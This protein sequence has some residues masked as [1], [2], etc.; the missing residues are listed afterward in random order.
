MRENKILRGIAA[1]PGISVKRV[2]IIETEEPSISEQGVTDV[3]KEIMKLSKALKQTKEQLSM[4][5]KKVFEMSDIH[6][7]KI[8]D[9][10]LLLLEDEDMIGKTVKIIR[11]TRKN[12][13]YAVKKV[14]GEMSPS[15]RKNPF[16]KDRLRDI[17]NV[18][19]KIVRNMGDGGGRTVY[20][21]M[22]KGDSVAAYDIPAFDMVFLGDVGG[23]ITELGGKTSHTAILARAFGVPAVVG[24]ESALRYL[25]SGDLVIIDGVRGV[26]V[27]NPGEETLRS[28]EERIRRYNDYRKGLT[29]L[30]TLSPTTIDGHTIEVSVNIELPMEIQPA[31]HYGADGIGLFRTEFLFINGPPTEPEQFEVYKHCAELV[32]PNSVI[33]RTVDIGGDKLLQ[34][35]RFHDTNPFLGWR[36]VRVYLKNKN[37]LRTQLRAVL[38][39]S[40]FGNVR[41]MFPFICAIEEIKLLKKELE[42]IKR[43]LDRDNIKYDRK[44]EL[45]IMV[46]IP[47][48]VILARDFAKEVDFFS[49]GSND[50]VQYTLAC[51]R[52]NPR[53]A[54]SFRPLHPAV[55]RLIKTT[56]DSGHSEDIWVGLCGEL[57][58][59]LIA[60]PLLLGLGLD[61]LSVSPGALLPVKSIIRQITLEE[62]HEIADE[63]LSISSATEVEKYLGSI[64]KKRVGED[65]LLPL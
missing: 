2:L 44:I 4:V 27:V 51:D 50:L 59:E 13:E 3:E 8:F 37:I 28:Y 18:V 22:E 17:E 41:I 11:R 21:A 12:A 40:A 63:V 7:A 56:I 48:A 19:S 39:A 30:S 36:A 42:K 62:C 23:I 57:A 32:S 14:I 52:G 65:K 26:V 29:S 15:M 54:D 31:M 45:G 53:V 16:F 5:Q 58:S 1:S 55:I 46:E 35:E 20:A 61:E 38:R 6:S 47:S 49:I 10:Q 25:K 60:V 33:I 9:A 64:I 24:V 43:E 34:D